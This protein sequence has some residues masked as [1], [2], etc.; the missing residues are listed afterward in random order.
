[1]DVEETAFTAK[2]RTV[3]LLV[4]KA[5]E[6]AEGARARAQSERRKSEECKAKWRI[7]GLPPSS[8]PPAPAVPPNPP[9]K[10]GGSG[11]ASPPSV[12]SSTA[13]RMARGSEGLPALS[14]SSPLRG[15]HEW[16]RSLGRE[17]AASSSSSSG[18]AKSRE[19]ECQSP[20]SEPRLGRS[21]AWLCEAANRS[22]EGDVEGARHALRM[23]K[24]ARIPPPPGRWPV[25]LFRCSPLVRCCLGFPLTAERM[26]L[27][28]LL[29]PPASLLC[30]RLQTARRSC[31]LSSSE[32]RSCCRG[33]GV[34][35]KGRAARPRHHRRRPGPREPWACTVVRWTSRMPAW[36]TG[37]R[38]P[39]P[40]R[41]R[42]R[43]CWHRRASPR[44]EGSRDRAVSMPTVV[45]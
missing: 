15:G 2:Q 44:S 4:A 31:M 41:W 45:L 39:C 10:E 35:P 27:Q 29:S 22:L 9:S 1:M 32:C 20:E 13:T 21:T 11:H 3:E 33:I 5:I 24:Q 42:A 43:R 25:L 40:L 19:E 36:T 26:S 37:S 12:T 34:W 28:T 17:A 18:A 14:P 38:R 8:P 23:T 7:R 30:P 16:A 6:L